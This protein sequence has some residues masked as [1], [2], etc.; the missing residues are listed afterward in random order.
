MS[1]KLYAHRIAKDRWWMFAAGVRA[2]YLSE[3]P[4]IKMVDALADAQTYAEFVD[5]VDA[6]VEDDWTVDLQLFDEGETWL[7]RAL[8]RGWFF[9]NNSDRWREGFGVE[10]V[11]YD[12]R[13][14]VPPE[15]EKNAATADWVDRQIEMHA[16]VTF[17]VLTRAD[18][19]DVGIIVLRRQALA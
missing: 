5:C 17:Q 15:D 13:S 16:Y 19:L 4:V 18:L 3:H 6:L 12:T 7:I 11:C 2:I 1:T 8:E 10:E 14:E 9:N